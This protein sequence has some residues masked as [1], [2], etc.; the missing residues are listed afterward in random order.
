MSKEVVDAVR[1]NIFELV[2][3]ETGRKLGE[4]SIVTEVFEVTPDVVKARF[5]PLSVY[6][7]TAVDLGRRIKA[8]GEK[9]SGL[10]KMVVECSGH[11]QDELVNRLV[12]LEK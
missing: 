11:M 10:K 7:P 8:A 1:A 2:E 3:E 4:L 12:N 9:V 6:S 5:T